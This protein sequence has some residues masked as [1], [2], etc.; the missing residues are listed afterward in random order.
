MDVIFNSVGILGM[1]CFLTA[2]F[3][4]QKGT[5]LP[6]SYAYLN[7]NLAGAVLI[8]AS[9]LWDWNLPAFLLEAAWF[10]ITSYGIYKRWRKDKAAA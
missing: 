7:M 2:Y 1:A 5:F 6:N 4:L 3:F 9:L 10:V 8:I